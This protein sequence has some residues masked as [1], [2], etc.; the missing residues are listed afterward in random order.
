VDSSSN[1]ALT[2][3]WETM[4]LGKDFS[5]KDIGKDGWFSSKAADKYK[6]LNRQ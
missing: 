6:E 1:D 2:K 4:D 5:Q 3:Q